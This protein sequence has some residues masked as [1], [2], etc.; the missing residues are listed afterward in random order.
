MI[1]IKM[2]DKQKIKGSI[3]MYCYFFFKSIKLM[4][5]QFFIH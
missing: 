1:I 5:Q 3:F 2:R 4:V